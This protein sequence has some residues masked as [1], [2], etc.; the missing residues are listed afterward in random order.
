MYLFHISQCIIQNR[1]VHI[2]ALNGE[3]WDMERVPYGIC[4]IGLLKN[5]DRTLNSS[6]T[7]HL[8][9]GKPWG[10]HGETF[11]EIIPY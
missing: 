7:R 4:E 2:S 1:N 8:T 10:T 5:I 9:P 3:F 11:R 6:N